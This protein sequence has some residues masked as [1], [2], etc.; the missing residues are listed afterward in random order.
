MLSGYGLSLVDG[1]M[2]KQ[3]FELLV[4]VRK[5]AN[6]T[7]RISWLSKSFLA[8]KER[9]VMARMVARELRSSGKLRCIVD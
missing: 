6:G 9:A 8:I 5:K 2:P 3:G 7:G 1:F 4:V